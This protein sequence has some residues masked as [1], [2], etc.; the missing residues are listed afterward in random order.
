MGKGRGREIGEG[1]RRGR[2]NGEGERE[3]EQLLFI[4]CTDEL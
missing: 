2:E 1:K 4:Q 3:G